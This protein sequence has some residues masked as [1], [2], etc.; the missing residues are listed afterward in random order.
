[1]T[2]QTYGSSLLSPNGRRRAQFLLTE[3]HRSGFVSGV[4]LS[5][6]TYS[7][8]FQSGLFPVT[9]A[10]LLTCLI[11]LL[12]TNA[13]QAADAAVKPFD[14]PSGAAS[15]T[16]KLFAQQSGREIVFSAESIGGTATNAVRG[17]LTAR[18]A[19][20][21]MTAG[22][23]L[24]VGVDEK[25]GLFS[26]RKE[27]TVP[28][29]PRAT[30][31]APALARPSQDAGEEPKA[32]VLSPFEVSSD[33][34]VG[35]QA[36]NTTS[37]SRLN[38]SLKDTAASV[39]VFTPEFLADFGATSLAESVAYAPN[40]QI[41]KGDTSADATEA[42]GSGATQARIRVRGLA[43][44][45]ALD[46][47][48]TNVIIDN[49]N[50]ERMEL[51]SG[52]NSILFGFAAPGGLAAFATKRA[53]AARNRTSTRLQVGEWKFRR[54][55]LDHNQVLVPGKLALRV[56]GVQQN[57]DGW[58]T[59]DFSE[60]TRGALALRA[61]PWKGTTLNTSYENGHTLQHWQRSTNAFDSLRLWELRGKPLRSDLAWNAADRALGINQNAAV[62]NIYV[63]DAD[64]SPPFV[65]TTRNAPNFRLLQ[66]AYEDLNQPVAQRLGNTLVPAPQLPF[67]V[68]TYGP[69]ATRNYGFDR[70]LASV[71][72][73]FTPALSLEAA[74][75]REQT[76]A[77]VVSPNP[78]IF[79]YGDPN[80]V[81]PDPAGGA[82]AVP[83]PNAGGY[84]IEAT[85]TP[86]WQKDWR[87]GGR[88]ALAWD[89][90]LGKLGSHRLAVMAE[91]DRF[92]GVSYPG[93]EILVDDGGIPIGNAA[94][95]EN[96]ANVFIRRHYVT[97]G[98][99]DSYFGG[100]GR[101]NFTV[102]RNGRTY[103]NTWVHSN[104]A[105]G[106]N[107][108]TIDSAQLVTR[109]AFF[110]SRFVFTG[111]IRSDR[112]A[113][114]VTGNMRLPASDPEVVAGR[115]IANSLRYT[116]DIASRTL[117]KFVTSTVGGV[118]HVTPWL[119]A[120]YNQADNSSAPSLNARILPDL[121][122]PPPP[123]GVGRDYGLMFNLLG[124]RLFVRATSFRTRQTN[125]PGG[126]PLASGE[127]D[128]AS[129]NQR[130][131]D[132]LLANNR[133]SAAEQSQHTL[134]VSPGPA[135]SFDSLTTGH[136][137]SAWLNLSRSFTGII[138]F[139]YTR[140]DR[141]RIIPEFE[142]WFDRES[143][144]WHRTPGAGGLL[145]TV[146]A[147]TVDQEAA[148]IRRLIVGLRDLNNFSFGERPY[149]ANA[150]GRY[151]V[152]QGRLKGAFVGG[153]ARWQGASK[154]GRLV[155]G[156][157]AAKNR[158]FG[159]T[160]FGPEDFKLDGFLG[161]R[162]KLSGNRFRPELT[163]QI[164]VTN[165]TGEDSVM[166]LRYNPDKSGYTRVLLFEPRKF[167]LT[168]GMEF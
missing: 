14:V 133:I 127:F 113:F 129:P 34:D 37:G 52:P 38:S 98:K 48:D 125:Q 59:W 140:V 84:Y 60:I 138:N 96:A 17:E 101:Q 43:A 64:G 83:N 164:N 41:D 93:T 161:Y 71:T 55:E 146:S 160:F 46:F 154:L 25:S 63:T 57:A 108:R 47:F 144:F 26:V 134:A 94:V 156:L 40:L 130:I 11:L 23:G 104:V 16:L 120:F 99:F 95:P 81:I 123:E 124:D 107:R 72:H 89:V 35:Y 50:T 32:V 137:I 19:L 18:D 53:H 117:Y 102:V 82:L 158:I 136:E 65:L 15:R 165:L 3:K 77:R 168:A 145:N 7:P 103:H 54:F 76:R 152:Q 97:P 155:T 69:G 119:S 135:A 68:S 73:V 128:I 139:S 24:T 87:E 148:E 56:N 12:P 114:A 86:D 39:M 61:Q 36:G 22:T 126:P 110:N 91:H 6:M 85:W 163:V 62:R 111:G 167:R 8:R 90:P 21:R 157:D 143:A 141:S 9:R 5:P 112:T 121:S 142:G 79:L 162:R 33:K 4:T 80:T 67:D 20:D 115:A 149:K 42:L 45:V 147:S 116:S 49:Y 92:R 58:R 122:I 100:D 131:L 153:G 1:M 51:S 109:S 159:E 74:F 88:L 13:L 166:P 106:D 30:A 29:A 28:N 118:V 75:R 151:T 2:D 27:T 70:F 10:F 78:N 132:T 31:A 150:S 44:G 66:T 105:R